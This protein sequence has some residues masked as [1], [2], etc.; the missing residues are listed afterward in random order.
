MKTTYSVKLVLL[1]T[2]ALTIVFPAPAQGPAPVFA[3]RSQLN[4]M[5]M[6]A[7]VELQPGRLATGLL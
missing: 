7:M 6:P 4:L 5:P 3:E 1:L 2:F